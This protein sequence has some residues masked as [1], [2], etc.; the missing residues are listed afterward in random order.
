MSADSVLRLSV[1][2]EVW[3]LEHST[4]LYSPVWMGGPIAQRG[5]HSTLML[6]SFEGEENINNSLLPI[7]AAAHLTL[8]NYF[9]QTACE[10]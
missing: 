1:L 8:P 4:C 9:S 6:P 3:I 5:P 2:M 10:I 7:E